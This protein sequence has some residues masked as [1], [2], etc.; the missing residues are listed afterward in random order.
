MERGA[1]SVRG[2]E[3]GGEVD[4]EKIGVKKQCKR[5]IGTKRKSK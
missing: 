3:G 4:K 5:K 2:V 1:W